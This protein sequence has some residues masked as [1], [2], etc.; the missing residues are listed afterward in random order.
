MTWLQDLDDPRAHDEA[1]YIVSEFARN[2]IEIDGV[3]D[4]HGVAFMYAKDRLLAREEHL[5]RIQD[6]LGDRGRAEPVR[7]VIK[8]IVLLEISFFAEN[9]DRAAEGDQ[10]ASDGGGTPEVADSPARDN[11]RVREGEQPALLR[12]LDEIDEALGPGHATLDHV[13]TAAQSL[14]P[15]P[16]TEPEEVRDSKP[17]P[18]ACPGNDGAGVRIYVADTGVFFDTVARYTW[19]GGVLDYSDTDPR[20][21][22]DGT[23]LPYGGHGTFVAGVIGCL[24]P[25]AKIIVKNVFNIAGSQLESNFVPALQAGF[26]YGAGI[27]HLTIASPTRNNLPLIAFEA[28]LQ[29]LAEHEGVVCVVAAGN[30]NSNQKF[31]PAAFPGM[32]SVGALSKDGLSR[33]DFSN[34]GDWVKVYAPG[35]DLVNAFATGPYRC[36]V[37]PHIWEVRHFFGMARW[38]GTSFSTPIVTGLIAARMARQGESGVAAADALLNEAGTITIPGVGPC[39]VLMPSCG[40]GYGDEGD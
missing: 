26:D 11:E 9:D 28:W 3:A 14:H 17:D 25:G 24:A 2:R 1:A 33:A 22:P 12:L 34:Y 15:C 21:A 10:P 18:P 19:L 16:A 23:I 30:C 20:I 39:P 13:L 38:S 32:V 29:D 6:I 8:D 40:D 37:S 5:E 31:W 4:E 27:F 7:R 35:Q 36:Y